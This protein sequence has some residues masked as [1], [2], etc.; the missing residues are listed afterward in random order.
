MKVDIPFFEDPVLLK[1]EIWRAKEKEG[2]LYIPNGS[3]ETTEVIL[4][5]FVSVNQLSIYGAVADVGGR[6]ILE[7]IQKLKG[8]GE[9]GAPEN[10][11]T[12]LMPPEMSNTNRTS[13]TDAGVQGNL[14]R[15]YEQRFA[16]LPGHAKL[17]KLCS[18]A[19][20]AKTVEKGQFFTTLDDTELDRMRGSCRE[21]AL[22]RSDQSSQ[23]KGWIGQVLD[24]MVCYHQGCYGV[25]S[26]VEP[27]V[28]DKTCS[29]VKIMN[30]INKYVTEMSEETHVESIGEK[31]TRKPVA[32]AR[33]QPRCLLCLFRTVNESG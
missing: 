29:W 24:V 10:L 20:L 28:G 27:P 17:I 5:T 15:E 12:T 8:F 18:I 25:E 13:Q 3:D 33:P 1:E 2:R 9:P 23:V 21:Y 4:R 26:M 16:D 32:K 6:I 22:P 11:E 30:G 31:G 14:L 7:G 19:G